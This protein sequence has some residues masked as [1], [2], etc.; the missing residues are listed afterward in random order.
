MEREGLTSLFSTKEEMYWMTLGW[1][2]CWREGGRE[3][4]G[5]DLPCS[6]ILP[7]NA[8]LQQ[9]NLLNAVLPSLGVHHV[10]DLQ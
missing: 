9:V 1:L 7:L 2:S 5:C 4:G 8:H 3:I 10:E 6:T